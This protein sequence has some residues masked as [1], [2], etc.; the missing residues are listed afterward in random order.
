MA[1]VSASSSVLRISY[2]QGNSCIGKVQRLQFINPSVNRIFSNAT[3][4]SL[5]RA[6]CFALQG[7]GGFQTITRSDDDDILSHPSDTVNGDKN[8]SVDSM[9]QADDVAV[10]TN[11]ADVAS[12]T[13]EFSSYDD[14]V[15]LD[16]PT[17]GFSS[18]P[19]AIE[20]IRQGKFVIV[21]D[22]EDR[23]NEGDLIMA[24]S[25]VTPEAMAFIVRHGTGIVCVSMKEE[26]LER[27]HLP[28]M[29]TAKENEEKLC[30]AFT[31]SVDAKNGTT[32]G[33]SAKD[34]AKTILALADTSSRPEDFNRPGHIFPLKYREGGVLKRA[35][36]TEAS[37]DLTVLAGLSPVAVLC[38]LVDEDDGSMARLPKLREI[39]KRENLK[40]ISIADLIRYRRK[41]EKLVERASVARLPLKWGNVEAYCYRS[42]LDGIEHIAMVK[43][44]IGDGQDILVRVHSE[45]LTGD[46]FGSAR[47]DCGNQL[48]MA[49][50]LI[51][52]HGRGVLV[53]L[54]GHEG[55]GIGL[56]HKLRAYNLQDAG[57][58]TV[59]A[60]EELGLPVDSREYGIGAQ[61]LHDLGVR[62]MKLLTNNPAKYSGLKGYGLS[63]VGRVPLL[64]L[65]TKENQR[66]LE[67]KR[68]KMGHIYGT[69][70]NGRLIAS[71]ENKDSDKE[72]P[73]S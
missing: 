2:P 33:V 71:P 30:T 60:N 54:R 69:E 15:D 24:A 37:V 63:V 14:E 41:R 73:S 10:G 32:T 45:C 57:R 17:E 3:T 38:E 52:K 28:L 23:E 61:I 46:I 19:E 70:F 7:D 13:D 1:S 68:K 72:Q 55:R 21:V 26:D 40:I 4:I 18:I 27:L 11:A 42:L 29:V 64:T 39:A 9:L 53:Y 50:E 43:G 25:K 12:V 20:D 8:T 65:I 58:D 22:D 67:T 51:E 31:V 56:G 44:N 48:A 35:G 66:Y 59:E 62:T 5:K 49:M 36:H 34:R 47:C 16:Y 6:T